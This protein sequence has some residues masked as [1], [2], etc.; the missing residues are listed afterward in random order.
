MA[1]QQL[2]YKNQQDET[3]RYVTD[4]FLRQI[5]SGVPGLNANRALARA[6][7]PRS[8]GA[9]ASKRLFESS[10][11]TGTPSFSLGKTGGAQKPIDTSQV[12]ARAVHG[13]DR[14][15][16]RAMTDQRCL[17][18][19]AVGLA[20]L[21]LAIAIY[22]TYVHYRG[23]KVLCLSSGGCETVQASRYAKLGGVP[24]AADRARRLRLDPRRHSRSPRRERAHSA[25][26]GAG[27]HRLGLQRLPDLS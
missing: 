26:L 11:F 7:S 16:A 13:R 12:D 22:L 19:A 14:S 9:D 8:R 27:R 6:M 20:A 21:G 18:L 1:V 5:S 3:T 4:D 17:R 10:G 15:A 24:V 2:F 23:L 25:C